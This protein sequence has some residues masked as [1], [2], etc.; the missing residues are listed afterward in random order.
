LVIRAVDAYASPDVGDDDLDNY[1]HIDFAPL[2]VLARVACFFERQIE[3]SPGHRL[4]HADVWA[5][6]R[7]WCRSHDL[8]G[9]ITANDFAV[10]ALLIRQ[11]KQ[12]AVR[13]RGGQVVCVDVRLRQAPVPSKKAA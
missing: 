10:T 13:A 7:E 4:S 12:I 3:T 6:F 2:L 1:K 9:N 11:I 5:A 8:K